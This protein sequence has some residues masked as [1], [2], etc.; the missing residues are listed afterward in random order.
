MPGYD[1]LIY[2]NYNAL[3]AGFS[4]DGRTLFVNLYSPTKTL[5]ITGPWI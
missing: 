1:V 2:D 3:A 4:P 5:A